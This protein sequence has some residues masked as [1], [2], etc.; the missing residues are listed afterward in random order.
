M[1]IMT[2]TEKRWLECTEIKAAGDGTYDA[3]L[4]TDR[5]DRDGES[6]QPKC[7]EP[8]PNS[9]PFLLDHVYKTDACIGSMAP[10]Y[11]GDVLKAKISFSSLPKAQ[12]MKTLVDEGHLKS[13]SVSFYTRDRQVVK[14]V[15]T[16]LKGDLVEASLVIIPSNVDAMIT[17]GSKSFEPDV[18]S[19]ALDGS[20]EHLAQRLR[21]ALK[22]GG[23]G[24]VYIRGT[25]PDRVVYEGWNSDKDESEIAVATY[26]ID[27]SSK[28]ISIGTGEIVTVVETI[29]KPTKSAADPASKEPGDAAETDPATDL[30]LALAHASKSQAEITLLL[31]RKAA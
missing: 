24:Y 30:A 12:A 17:G 10:F 16:I 31:A 8:L 19:K 25:Y 23:M 11:D 21:Q 3:V 7:F 14:G 2:L 27:V 1:A 22:D 15:P 9:M 20:Y 18:Q 6:L 5:V 26:S 13:M 4:S 29:V 28:T